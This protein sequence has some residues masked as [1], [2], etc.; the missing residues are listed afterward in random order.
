ME[1]AL[2][3]SLAG[4]A[5]VDSTSIGTLVIPIW[6]LLSGR[7]SIGRPFAVYLITITGFYLALGVLVLQGLH[8]AAPD[9]DRLLSNPAAVWTQAVIGTGLLIFALLPA[10]RAKRATG[11]LARWQARV[12]GGTLSIRAAA[13]LALA[14]GLLEAASMV[15]YIAAIALLLGAGIS[16][17]TEIVLLAGYVMVMVL[18]ATALFAGRAV[19]FHKL[20]P[21]LSRAGNWLTQRADEAFQWA[22]GIVGFL[23]ARDALARLLAPDFFNSI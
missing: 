3:L 11:R 5:L 23:L 15:P 10:S 19:A 18:P 14:A 9:I 16:P 20:Q 8:L 7:R 4:L 12:H 21:W 17:A 22:L 6:L 2:L 1:L 13:G